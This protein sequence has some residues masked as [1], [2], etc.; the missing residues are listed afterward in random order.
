MSTPETL[1]EA[2]SPP[3]DVVLELASEP[4]AQPELSYVSLDPSAEPIAVNTVLDPEA[5]SLSV[6]WSD[7]SSLSLDHADLDRTVAEL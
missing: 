4:V 6:Q 7:G 5:S 2:S 1:L 3:L